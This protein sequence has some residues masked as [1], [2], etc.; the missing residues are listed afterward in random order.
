MSID[1]TNALKCALNPSSPPQAQTEALAHLAAFEQSQQCLPFVISKLALSTDHELLFYSLNCIS[2]FLHSKTSSLSLTDLYLL[3]DHVLSFFTSLHPLVPRHLLSKTLVV[4]IHLSRL[5]IASDPSQFPCPFQ[6]IFEKSISWYNGEKS[7]KEMGVEL[8]FIFNSCFDEIVVGYDQSKTEI[9]ID[10][11]NKVKNLIKQEH[12]TI[13]LLN[14]VHE[15]LNVLVQNFDLFSISRVL[16]VASFFFGWLDPKICFE[17]FYNPILLPLLQNFGPNNSENSSLLLSIS[18]CL[19]HL[20]HKRSDP[21]TK[22]KI[23]GQISIEDFVPIFAKVKDPDVLN[24]FISFLTDFVEQSVALPVELS[25]SNLIALKPRIILCFEFIFNYCFF[26]TFISAGNGITIFIKLLK[27][28]SLF[29]HNDLVLIVPKFLSTMLNQCKITTKDKQNDEEFQSYRHSIGQFIRNVS[30][31]CQAQVKS[32]VISSM[33]WIMENNINSIDLEALLFI[34]DKYFEAINHSNDSEL[35]KFFK[36]IFTKISELAINLNSSLVSIHLLELSIRNNYL[37]NNQLILNLY[38]TNS[39]LFS[40]NSLIVKNSLHLLSR[41]LTKFDLSNSINSNQIINNLTKILNKHNDNQIDSIIV[42]CFGRLISS[43]DDVISVVDGL[44]NV[45]KND[46]DFISLLASLLKGFS[47]KMKRLLLTLNCLRAKVFH[48]K[49]LNYIVSFINFKLVISLDPIIIENQTSIKS[50]LISVIQ[51]AVD[52]IPSFLIESSLSEEL[53]KLLSFCLNYPDLTLFIGMLGKFLDL[54]IFIQKLPNYI[55]EVV[56]ISE[57]GIFSLSLNEI[58]YQPFSE[59][60]REHSNFQKILFSLLKSFSNTD[61]YDLSL[62]TV[63]LPIST[64]LFAAEE[65]MIRKFALN[66]SCCLIKSTNILHDSMFSKFLC[67]NLI[68]LT[69]SK[70]INC[71]ALLSPEGYGCIKESILMVYLILSS[72]KNSSEHVNLLH[73]SL[74]NLI[75]TEATNHFL[76]SLLSISDIFVENNQELKNWLNSFIQ[77]LNS[78][79]NAKS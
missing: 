37:F 59:I 41:F 18:T 6:L 2:N 31:L 15:F 51:M 56:K 39:V 22:V 8:F 48:E 44:E 33:K 9:E 30:K 11:C 38:F 16:T 64:T 55:L 58:S 26:E 21:E 50:K 60:H 19:F 20:I 25:Q 71:G 42:Q 62:L 65:L 7:S 12:Y 46:L 57:S 54:G 24:S 28:I 75:G 76:N 4:V 40:N 27:N 29:F 17:K 10:C 35:S 13:K 36:E 72:F 74:S 45:S 53:S 63:L 78:K 32:F 23:L 68:P 73:R 14:Y 79:I 47:S 69:V 43:I 66:F 5:I 77:F 52:F 1:I 67:E 49:I 3:R 34:Y 70:P 61:A